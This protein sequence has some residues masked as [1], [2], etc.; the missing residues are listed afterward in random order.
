MQENKCPIDPSPVAVPAAPGPGPL[1]RFNAWL[2]QTVPRHISV[3]TFTVVFFTSINRKQVPF[4][5]PVSLR[6]GCQGS[7]ELGSAYRCPGKELEMDYKCH[8]PVT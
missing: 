5:A 4:F 1:S 7:P 2:T 8:V 3:L 6:H